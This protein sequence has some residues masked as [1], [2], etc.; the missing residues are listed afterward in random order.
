MVTENN[1]CFAEYGVKEECKRC[2]AKSS[3]KRKR[4]KIVNAAWNHDISPKTVE[5]Y[6]EREKERKALKNLSAEVTM[7]KRK[8]HDSRYLYTKLL[9]KHLK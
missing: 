6:M 3:C 2:A 1:T 7:A 5:E 4:D 8:L 9:K